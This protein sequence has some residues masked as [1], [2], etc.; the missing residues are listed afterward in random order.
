MNRRYA[1]AQEAFT[2]SEY[3]SASV[4]IAQ[5]ETVDRPFPDIPRAIRSPYKRAASADAHIH[6]DCL[7]AQ[8]LADHKVLL[9]GT[10]L[11]PNM[12]SAGGLTCQVICNAM[13]RAMTSKDL[14]ASGL[15]ALLEENPNQIC[16]DCRASHTVLSSASIAL[17]TGRAR[18]SACDSISCKH[19]VT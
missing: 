17:F 3:R 12:V 13:L 11:K 15:Q 2:L 9:E 14:K 10:L 6:A 4:I 7:S 16:G 5:R 8:A 19:A 1:A 18:G